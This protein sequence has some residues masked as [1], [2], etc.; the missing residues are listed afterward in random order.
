MSRSPLLLSLAAAAATLLA[1]G[2]ARAGVTLVFQRGGQ[3]V[4]TMMLDGAH[5]RFES[6]G[7]GSHGGVMI[8]DGEGKRQ[9]VIDDAAK[10]Y[11]VITPEDMRHMRQRMVEARTQAQARMKNMAPEQR[12][13]L[14]ALV[15]RQMPLGSNGK[16]PV[17]KYQR[18]NAKRKI[19][20]YPCEMYQVLIDGQPRVEEC[21]AGWNAGVAQKSDFAGLRTFADEVMKAGGGEELF[22]Q[23]QKAPG[24]PIARAH[25]DQDG[26]PGEEEQ[27]KSVER[28]AIPAARFEIPQGYTKREMPSMAAPGSPGAPPAGGPFRP[29]PPPPPPPKQ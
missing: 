7:R 22:A 23:I 24:F 29:L 20:G 21:V 25:I 4:S 28:G 27:L 18:M 14:E 16:P 8:V 11:M 9:I 5:L 1:G 17:I 13:R 3:P 2:L 6:T 12:K 19:A 26:T 15:G 10:T